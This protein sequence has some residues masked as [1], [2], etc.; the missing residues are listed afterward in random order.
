M[1]VQG[2]TFH[3][4]LLF[5]APYLFEMVVIPALI[6]FSNMSNISGSLNNSNLNSVVFRAA[7]QARSDEVKY[8]ASCLVCMLNYEPED[9]AGNSAGSLLYN[10]Q[11][12]QLAKKM[13][14]T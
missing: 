9:L 13:L 1:E 5:T 3:S 11:I 10:F 6:S 2:D 7:S 8:W 14:K 12:Y 4:Y